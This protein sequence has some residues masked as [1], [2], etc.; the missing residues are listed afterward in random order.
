MKRAIELKWTVILFAMT[1]LW[2]LFEKMMGWHG[3]RID[4]HAL[5]SNL[6]D[7]LFVV[8]FIFSLLEER[9]KAANQKFSWRQGFL[10]G[11]IIA[12]L[13]TA[14]SPL[15]QFLTHRLISPEFFPNIINFAVDNGVLSRE[16]ASAKFN[17]NNYI[18]ENLIGTAILGTACA[19][20]LPIF[21]IKK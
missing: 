16:T 12:G 5:Y 14:L 9:K 6:Y 10:S 20:I 7:L 2:K 15:T 21:M 4:Q 17:L 8:L 19:L 3:P 1:L 13:I 11:I 18:L